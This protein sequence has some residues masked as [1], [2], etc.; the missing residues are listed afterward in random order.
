MNGNLLMQTKTHKFFNAPTRQA[1]FEK[2][3]G[4]VDKSVDIA[5][6]IRRVKSTYGLDRVYRFDLGENADGY[7][8]KVEACLQSLSSDRRRFHRFNEYPDP[9]QTTL[10]LRLAARHGIPPEWIVLG[11]GVD[12]L[13]DIVA[14]VF[15]D[16]RDAYL[17]PVPSFFLFEA[18]SERMGAVPFFLQLREED[19]FRWT[20]QTIRRF[21]QLVDKVRPKLIWIANP[22]NPTGYILHEMVL[23]ELVDYASA[24]NSF[25]VVDEAFGEY[26]D[27]SGHPLTASR[28]LSRFQNLIVLRTFSKMYGLAS[29]RIGYLMCSSSDILEG[30]QIHRHPFPVTQLSADLAL[31]ALEDEAFLDSTRALNVMARKEVFTHLEGLA[32]IEAIPSYTNVFMARHQA[33]DGPTFRIA[34]ERRGILAAPLGISGIKGRGFLRFTLR[35]QEDNSYLCRVLEDLKDVEGPHPEALIRM[36]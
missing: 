7:S 31:V 13:L 35:N 21:K 30:I 28:L 1:M 5:A 14:R 16:H 8:P 29:F 24:N 6:E 36:S 18:L 26:T 12:S 11:T 25:V 22:N 2:V 33:M 10:R 19:Q 32:H 17:M 4:Y 15:L 34:L 3:K 27:P 20:H 23:D 9:H